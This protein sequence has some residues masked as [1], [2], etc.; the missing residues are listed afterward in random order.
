MRICDPKDR[1]RRPTL[2][3]WPAPPAQTS[4]FLSPMTIGSRA[5]TLTAFSS[6][7]RWQECP[8]ELTL[9]HQQLYLLAHQLIENLKKRA[10][11][12]KTGAPSLRVICAR[13][14]FHNRVQL[15]TDFTS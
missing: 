5:S 12:Y 15:H 2:F 8:S 11:I 7:Y 6:S 14:G 1:S 13:V 3:S 9:P 10:F 4:I